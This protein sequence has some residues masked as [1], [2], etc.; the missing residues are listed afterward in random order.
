M[1]RSLRVLVATAVGMG[2]VLGIAAAGTAG[3]DDAP[4][5]TCSNPAS[6]E[7]GD[8]LVVRGRLW[9]PGS[10]VTL[11]FDE[12]TDDFD[13]DVTDD[14]TPDDDDDVT[15][16]TTPDDDDDVTDDTTPDDDDDDV[17]DDGGLATA[18]VGDNGRFRVEVVVPETA[19]RGT[20]SINVVGIDEDGSSAHCAR[21]VRLSD[22]PDVETTDSTEPDDSDDTDDTTPTTDGTTPTTDGTSDDTTPTT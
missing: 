8:D 1:R 2:G 17:S 18:E 12:G 22:H 4:L 11:F 19:V 16:D 5:P 7:Q 20:H 10:T 3:T 15:D 6:S 9:E 13:D 21:T 14:T